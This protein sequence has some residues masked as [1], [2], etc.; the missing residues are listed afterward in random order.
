MTLSTTLRGR[1]VTKSTQ[2]QVGRASAQKQT[3]KT[4]ARGQRSDNTRDGTTSKV[5]ETED[6]SGTLDDDP[7]ASENEESRSIYDISSGDEH[8]DSDA[9]EANTRGLMG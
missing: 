8:N 3:G 7:Y 1:S 9:A 6:V 2:D 5:V 4:Q